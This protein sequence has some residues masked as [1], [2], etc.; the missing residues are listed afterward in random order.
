[1][2]QEHSNNG[3]RQ[4][5][6]DDRIDRLEKKIDI[7]MDNH[8]SHLKSSLDS[9]HVNVDWLKRFFWLMITAT[10]GSFITAL[11]TLIFK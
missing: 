11:V 4:D 9:L 2:K 1:M 10:V 3:Y 6:Q 7:I 8:L 5:M